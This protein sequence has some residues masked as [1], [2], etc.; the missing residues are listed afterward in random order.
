MSIGEL[1]RPPISW[2][3]EPW[4]QEVVF[5]RISAKTLAL[6][7]ED[8]R[9]IDGQE[10]N[11][12]AAIKF[13]AALLAATVV[14]HEATAEQWLAETT[15]ETLTTLGQKAMEVN[16][17]VAEEA[18]KNSISPSIDSPLNSVDS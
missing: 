6:M 9:V 11:T 10:T 5:R 15:I 8:L 3:Y 4:G 1:D 16:K 14:S 17:L 7:A 12:P 13:F 2:R 18:K